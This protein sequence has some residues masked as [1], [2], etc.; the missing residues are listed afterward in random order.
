MSRLNPYLF[1]DALVTLKRNRTRT[2]LAGL[3]V[4]FGVFILLVSI[5]GFNIFYNGSFGLISKY[6]LESVLIN[7]NPTTREY[8]GFGAG[9]EWDLEKGDVET[10]RHQFRN[11]VTDIGPV[12]VYPDKQLVLPGNGKRD[13]VEV[14]ATHPEVFSLLS[15]SMASGR[16]IDEIDMRNRRKVCVVGRGLAERW[17]RKDEEPLGKDILVG[18][19]SYTIVGII[20]KDNSMVQPFDD[21]TYCVLIPYSTADAVNNLEGKVTHLVFSLEATEG[22][23]HK[24]EEIIRYL[25]QLHSVDPD[26]ADSAK[27][28]SMQDYSQML[29]TVF[30]GTDVLFWVVFIGIVLSSLLGVFGIML[31][32]VR[33][34]KSEIAIRLSM[35][36]LPED[37][38]RQFV[39]E[40]LV[41][42]TFS[43]FSGLAIAEAVLA[44]IRLMFRRGII[45]DPLF[46]LPQLSFGGVLAVLAIVIAGGV[47]S[48]YIPARKM[49]DKQIAELF[50]EID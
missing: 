17:F 47:L 24:R 18:G 32:S 48:G 38:E 20:R 22:Y 10:I 31:L 6:N 35:G 25:K 27:V 1:R 36:A 49:A 39:S 7:T 40:S 30:D 19:I 11:T 50:E 2:L 29:N 14:T 37:I 16:F 28:T 5:A 46:G 15:T 9:R 41:I 12:Y 3:A 33:E 23:E 8:D 34:R 43:A 42:S 21:E 45:S 13:Y 44:V 26:D 4:T